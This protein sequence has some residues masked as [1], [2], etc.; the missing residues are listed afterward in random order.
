MTLQ[1][2]FTYYTAQEACN[3]KTWY[4]VIYGS[5][6]H[7]IRSA[8]ITANVESNIRASYIPHHLKKGPYF[9][10]STSKCSIVVYIQGVHVFYVY[11]NCFFLNSRCKKALLVM[12]LNNKTCLQTNKRVSNQNIFLFYLFEHKVKVMFYS[13]AVTVIV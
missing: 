4:F 8:M 13:L 9:Q 6:F 10:D 11:E 5:P 2:P 7:I 3:E 12:H 1:T